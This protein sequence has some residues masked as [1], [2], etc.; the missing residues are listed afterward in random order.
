LSFTE[1]VI[2]QR[3]MYCASY[4]YTSEALPLQKVGVLHKLFV[5]LLPWVKLILVKI[6]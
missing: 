5:I 6:S 1:L 3:A 4:K 2:F